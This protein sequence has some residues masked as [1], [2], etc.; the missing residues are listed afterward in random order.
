MFYI[1]VIQC[2]FSSKSDD[3]VCVYLEQAQSPEDAE[4]QAKQDL[5]FYDEYSVDDHIFD[6][7]AKAVSAQNIGLVYSEN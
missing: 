3:R 5:Q 4:R 1:V 7:S 6:I 2:W